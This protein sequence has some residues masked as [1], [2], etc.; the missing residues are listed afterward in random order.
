MKSKRPKNGRSQLVNRVV[1]RLRQSYRPIQIILFGSYAHGH[2][3]PDSDLDLLIVKQTPKSFYQRLFDVRRLVSPVLGGHPFDPIVMTPAEL[4][5][6]GSRLL[7]YDAVVLYHVPKSS[8]EASKVE[9]LKDYVGQFGGGVLMVGLGGQLDQEIAQDAPLDALLPV[10]FDP[11]G[12][13]EAKRRVCIVLLVDRSTSMI[14]PRIAAAKRGAVELVK[15]LAPED[16]VGVL[17]FDTMPYVV[18]EVQRASQVTATLIEKLVR[19]RS[20]GGTD[21]LPALKAAQVRLQQSGATVKHMVLLS[22]GVTEPDP[23]GYQQ[24]M[25]ELTQQKITISTIG[26]GAAFVDTEFMGWLARSTDGTFY[27]MRSLDELPQLMIRDTQ[28]TLGQ[29]PFSEGYF[30]PVLAEGAAWF[31]RTVAWPVLKGYLTATAKSGATA[32][33]EIRQAEEHSP[34][35]SHWEWGAGRVAV[36]TSDADTRWSS[37]WIRW[38]SFESVWAQIVREVMR[39]RPAEDVFVWTQQDQATPQVIIAGELQQPFAELIGADGQVMPLGLVQQGPFRWQ[40]AVSAGESGWYELVIGSHVSTPTQPGQEPSRASTAFTRRWVQIGQAQRGPEQPGLP[41]DEAILRR[42]AQTTGGV[43]DV[44]DRAFVPP[45][46]DV[47]VIV[48]RF[49][50]VL[51]LVILLVL[52]DIALRGRTML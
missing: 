14:G 38:P 49:R 4:P 3:G 28:H 16:L 17:A 31:D 1:K 40:A 52:A 24:L 12:A 20:T 5:L 7:D 44:P 23:K 9:A 8:I 32:E 41:P 43:F 45:T 39:R 37:E 18:V 15:Q 2:P 25:G 42:V 22:D 47:T 11:K 51:P 46:V 48:P 6:A 13:Q 21:I 29:L 30:Q 36:F 50:W 27:Q 26:I 19:L 10:H 33:L 35:L 34:L